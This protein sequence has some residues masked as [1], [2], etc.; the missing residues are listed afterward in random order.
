MNWQYSSA[1][2]RLGIALGSGAAKG[3]A[4][5]GVL[6]ELSKLGIQPH[7]IAGC[8]IG[9]Y[10]GAAFANDRLNELEQWVQTLTNWQVVKL[11]DLG[12]NQGGLLLG[13]KVFALTEALLGSRR[14]EASRLPFAAVATELYTG[15]EVWLKRGNMRRAVRASC[16][17]PGLFSPIRWHGRWLID[18]AVSNPVPVSLCRAM[19]ASHVIAVDLQAN[20]IGENA[21]ANSPILLEDRRV[22]TEVLERQE[23]LFARAMGVGQGYFQSV[24]DKIG[25][26]R[27][28]K[29]P[30]QPNMMAVMSGALDILE[31]KLKRSRMAGDPPGV[32]IAPKVADIGLMEFFRAQEAIEAGRQAVRKQAE[33]LEIFRARS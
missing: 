26:H 16:A 10:V 6:D 15:R 5:I 1:Y 14:V 7:Y 3:W 25:R 8:S 2:P 23:S 27:K 28:P 21:I 4:H 12:I 32:L 24:V 18:G 29:D 13:K 20:R 22:P 30:T 17:M 19:G 11:L 31:D 33:V 9:A